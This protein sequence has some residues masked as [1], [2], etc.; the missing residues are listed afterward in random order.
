MSE[1]PLNATPTKDEEGKYFIR[2]VLHR[3]LGATLAL[4]D[5]QGYWLCWMGV[6]ETLHF[7]GQDIT[8]LT[9]Q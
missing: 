6:G 9:E 2:N 7:N 8:L 3:D 4:Y 5:P 1:E